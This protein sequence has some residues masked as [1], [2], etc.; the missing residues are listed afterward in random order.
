VNHIIDLPAPFLLSCFISGLSPTIRREVQV[1]QPISLAQAV[2]C[3]RLQEEKLLNAWRL[4]SYR[5]SSSTS[6]TLVPRS[7]QPPP[8]LPTSS[9]TTPPS[10]PF[11]RLTLEE[12]AAR[13]EKGL[14][15]HCDEKFS[16]G[17]KC[18]SSLFL[19]VIEDEDNPLDSGQTRPP[20]PPLET[21]AKPRML[22][23]AT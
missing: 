3:A 11:K 6:G 10:I 14:W 8:P 9:R 2:A 16:R 12:L 20:S 19:L 22:Y 7:T 23:R 13:R 1:L 4:S 5:L 21:F 18:A 17:H 15:F